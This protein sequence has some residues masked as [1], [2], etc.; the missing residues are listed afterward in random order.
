MLPGERRQRLPAEF[1]AESLHGL[2]EGLALAHGLLVARREESSLVLV[3]LAREQPVALL[4]VEPR[5]A[6]CLRGADV[7]GVVVALALERPVLVLAV[8]RRGIALDDVGRFVVGHNSGYVARPINRTGRSSG[9]SA[10]FWYRR[11]VLSIPTD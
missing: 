1:V 8:R 10:V 4:A 6:S 9:P 7:L 11:T 3:D 5:V 2:A